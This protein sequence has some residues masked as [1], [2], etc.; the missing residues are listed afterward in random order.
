M[1]VWG[2]M[3]TII[4]IGASAVTSELRCITSLKFARMI[5]LREYSN[6]PLILWHTKLIQTGLH[7]RTSRK[8]PQ[9][10]SSGNKP[11]DSKSK[12]PLNL[13]SIFPDYRIAPYRT[14]LEAQREEFLTELRGAYRHR[15]LALYLGA[16][17]SRS[18]NLPSWPELIRSLTVTMMTRKVNTAVNALAELKGEEFW[19]RT[20]TI[21]EDVAQLA[22]YDK[23][24]LMMAR[25]IKD[26]FG[27]Q[28]P[29]I[30]GRNLYRHVR[31]FSLQKTGD[32]R[33]TP[34]LRIP[35]SELLDSIVALARAE[36]D[37]EG[38]QAIVNYNYDDLM[39]E[40]LRQD[41]VRCITVRSGKDRIPD[42][43][44]PCYH[45]HGVIQSKHFLGR[46]VPSQSAEKMDI[47]NFVFSEDE[48]HAEYADAYKWSNMTQIGLLGRYTGL[49]VGLSLEDPNIR[50]LLDAT[51]KQYPDNIN[52]AILTRKH[53][54][55]SCH[56]SKQRVLTNLFEEVESKSFEKIGIK[57]VWVDS[58]EDIPKVIKGVCST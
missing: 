13:I 31:R 30:V 38:V 41:H 28:L 56:D 53:G 19:K 58:Y 33:Q 51:H 4:Y 23:P 44:L 16:G 20:G 40:K 24:I 15:G 11:N 54:N 1:V 32:R 21:Y 27:D 47:G 6:E 42:G 57:V 50:R 17:V 35:S 7:M 10:T 9:K 3:W 46:F 14:R 48:Y 34:T 49:F 29:Y 37:V 25:S 52:F 22:D 18:V 2:W 45:V 8:A 43:T 5:G 39:D 55:K 12:K 26:Q 36:R